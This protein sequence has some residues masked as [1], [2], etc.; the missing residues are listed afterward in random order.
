MISHGVK[1]SKLGIGIDFYGY[2]WSGGHG[3]PT[4]GVTEPRQSWSVDPWVQ[5][6]VPYHVIMETYY[7]RDVARWDS[8][9]EASY[10]SID[11]PGSA[12]DKFISY[13]NEM[14]CRK[15]VEY[16]ARKGLGGVF[17][18]ELGGGFWRN[19]PNGTQDP[20]LQEVKR[21]RQAISVQ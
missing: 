21:A 4:G 5:D 1:P 12:D 14:T 8:L 16:A 9:A 13:D 11:K 6:N 2:V 7:A 15:K 20:L 19:S 3:T 18:W 17:I 10:L